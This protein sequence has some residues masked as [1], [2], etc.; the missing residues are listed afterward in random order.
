MLDS[1]LFKAE[2]QCG[3]LVFT[4][5]SK[6]FLC[7]LTR[8]R[9]LDSS[10]YGVFRKGKIFGQK[11]KGSWPKLFWGFNKRNVEGLAISDF[12]IMGYVF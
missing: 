8:E 6:N 3:F 1:F 2:V 5:Y 12:R 7:G 10:F 9:V 4:N 11:W